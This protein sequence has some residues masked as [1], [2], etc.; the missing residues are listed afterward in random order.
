MSPFK[1]YILRL[2][3]SIAVSV[4]VV[5]LVIRPDSDSGTALWMLGISFLT[6][7]LFDLTIAAVR[8]SRNRCVEP[9]ALPPS[10]PAFQL[11][12]NQSD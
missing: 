3:V 8:A 1:R 10:H 12:G 9:P 7:A 5:Y 11:R 4:S 2:V 6:A